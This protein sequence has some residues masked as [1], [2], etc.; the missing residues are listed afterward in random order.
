MI[1]ID[2]RKI[3]NE[4]L[5]LT[6]Q[7][8][9]GLNFKPIL[10]DVLVGDDPVSLSYIGIK[11]RAAESAGAKFRLVHLSG[12]VT[13]EDVVSAIAREQAQ[14]DVRGLIVQLPLPKHIDKEQVIGAIDPGQDIDCLTPKNLSAFYSNHPRFIPPTAAA[15]I[16]I[17]DSLT[18]NL[19]NL[20]FVVVGQGS[21]VGKP[22]SFLLS[23][24]N[25]IVKVADRSTENLRTMLKTAD[26]VISGT[27][28]AGLI[29]PDMVKPNAII[30]DAGTAES[31]GSIVGDVDRTAFTNFSGQLSPVP[32]GVGPVT[33]AMLYQNL[34]QAALGQSS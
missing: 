34:L 7:G 2:G 13:T 10:V 32:G 16:R 30:I 9:T 18:I 3:A 11:S 19:S 27:G 25:Y 28:K 6:R 8:F 22:V 26:V 14:N 4:I 33:V 15:V 1:S 24:R 17:L 31:E 20:T 29:T 21:L 23:Q 12:P 5:K